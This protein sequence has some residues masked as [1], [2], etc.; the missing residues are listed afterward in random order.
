M[1][2]LFPVIPT[3]DTKHLVLIDST[4][5]IFAYIFP[6]P[7]HF[8]SMLKESDHIPAIQKLKFERVKSGTEQNRT[9]FTIREYIEW[10]DY[11]KDPYMNNH[12]FAN[13]PY[14][15][16]CRLQNRNLFLYCS[17]M[18]YIIVVEQ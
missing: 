18:L 2:L 11:S 17:N 8:I 16:S 9:T 12:I 15:T 3:Y 14:S 13:Q 7:E 10:G 1:H 4:K 5:A 6:I